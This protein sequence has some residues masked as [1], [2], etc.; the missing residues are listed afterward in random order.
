MVALLAP[1]QEVVAQ[2]DRDVAVFLQPLDEGPSAALVP[3]RY[4]LRIPPNATQV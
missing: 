3:D 2:A 4:I 1:T